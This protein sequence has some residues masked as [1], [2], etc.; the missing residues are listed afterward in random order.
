MALGA[1]P[2]RNTAPGQLGRPFD[3]FSTLSPSDAVGTPGSAGAVGTLG[4]ADS[5]STFTEELFGHLPRADQRKWAN[6]YLQGLL[7][8]PGKKTVRRLAATVFDSPTASQSLHQFVNSSPWPWEPARAGLTHWSARRLPLRAWSLGAA[9]LPKRGDRSV[10]VHRR[11]DPALG[12]TVNCQLGLG[13]FLAGG[14]HSIPVEWRLFLPAH[15]S[16]E[17]ALREGARIPDATRHEPLWAQAVD[18]VD[19]LAARTPLP[20]VPVVADLVGFLSPTQL[21]DALDARERDFVLSAPTDLPVLASGGR[22]GG[23]GDPGPTVVS[24]AHHVLGIGRTREPLP[25]TVATPDGGR[26]QLCVRSAL[27]RLPQDRPGTGSTQR[28][29]RLFAAR[30]PGEPWPAKVWISNLVHRRVDELLTLAHL[31]A[32]TACAVRALE[33]DFGL[34][35]FEGRSFPGWH[36]HLTLVSAAYAHHRLGWRDRAPGVQPPSPSRVPLQRR[37]A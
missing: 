33:D 36:R 26:R 8:T 28:T 16:E 18:L 14:R 19:T 12:R 4:S 24:R 25:I 29:Y 3:T 13:L 15:W 37:S 31:A 27:V 2:L 21:L 5:F 34:L 6:G 23:P 11:F 17:P 20:P 35:D 1:S 7:R 32:G 22:L 30:E 10:G 9:V